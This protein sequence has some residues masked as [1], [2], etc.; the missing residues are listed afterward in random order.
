MQIEI[1]GIKVK[2]N[3]SWKYTY[4]QTYQ[5]K[6]LKRNNPKAGMM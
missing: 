6:Y 3:I 5:K 4:I 2:V 1:K